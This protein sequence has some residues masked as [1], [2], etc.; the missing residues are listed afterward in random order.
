M[1]ALH[2]SK[3]V[4]RICWGKAAGCLGGRGV[5]AHFSSGSSCLRI[6]V[7]TDS[8][9]VSVR[10]LHPNGSIQLL[11]PIITWPTCAANV[12]TDTMIHVDCAYGAALA[13]EHSR[14]CVG[15][16]DSC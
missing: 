4:Y 1:L 8:R 13:S 6:H 3:L 12:N 2:S 5:E 9:C 10:P 16:D 11:P 14:S 15:L 7:Q